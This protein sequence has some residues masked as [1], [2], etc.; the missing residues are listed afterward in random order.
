MTYN[1]VIDNNYYVYSE[2][3]L[4]EFVQDESESTRFGGIKISFC[5]EAD[6]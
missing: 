3:I 1:V 2:I 6:G 5:S 4:S